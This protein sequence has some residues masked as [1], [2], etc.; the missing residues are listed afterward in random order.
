MA[1]N[2]IIIW[3]N[4]ETVAAVGGYMREF[5]D[6]VERLV[7]KAGCDEGNW[8]QVEPFVLRNLIEILA[9]E[10]NYG[11]GR[12]EMLAMASL[13]PLDNVLHVLMTSGERARTMVV[14]AAR[15]IRKE[16]PLDTFCAVLVEQEEEQVVFR[17]LDSS[18]MEAI[19]A[20][21][22]RD[23]R[24]THDA[25]QAACDDIIDSARTIQPGETWME[26]L[27]TL[28][29]GDLPEQDDLEE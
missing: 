7:K 19:I 22:E 23:E 13:V 2:K 4:E 3:Q 8:P 27:Q 10:P 15:A 5:N 20:R 25:A 14:R 1:I 16:R 21:Q 26:D 6:V 24:E 17:P 12:S 28:D 18:K 11:M 29:D 9:G